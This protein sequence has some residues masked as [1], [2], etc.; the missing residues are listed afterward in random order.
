MYM[1]TFCVHI[2]II[3]K[4]NK[5]KFSIVLNLILFFSVAPPTLKSLICEWSNSVVKHVLLAC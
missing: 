2:Y 3:V 1:W 4:I 5:T